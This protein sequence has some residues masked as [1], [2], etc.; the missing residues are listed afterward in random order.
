VAAAAGSSDGA[1]GAVDIDVRGGTVALALNSNSQLVEF[2]PLPGTGRAAGPPSATSSSCPSYARLEAAACV[3]SGSLHT[4]SS[5]SRKVQ[6]I[7]GYVMAL[8]HQP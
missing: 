7:C 6:G 3:P 2:G 1:G 5:S 4:S 8:E